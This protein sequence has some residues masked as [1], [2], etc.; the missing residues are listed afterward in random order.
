MNTLTKKIIPV[1]PVNFAKFGK[2]VSLPRE[3]PTAEGD[4]FF[5]S[6]RILPIIES[7]VK[8]KSGSARSLFLEVIG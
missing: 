3:K 6:G 2:V 8:P 7:M 4:T 5:Y 1:N